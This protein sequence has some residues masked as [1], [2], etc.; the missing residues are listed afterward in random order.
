MMIETTGVTYTIS[1]G[2]LQKIVL[3]TALGCQGVQA[4]KGKGIVIRHEGPKL[5][6]EVHIQAT[7]GLNLRTVALTVQQQV[8]QA[9]QQMVAPA[10]LQVH[11]SIEDL[12]IPE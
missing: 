6:V 10:E 7:Y 2:A 4:K 12:T 9:L 5:L 11:V 8:T 3:K 1:D